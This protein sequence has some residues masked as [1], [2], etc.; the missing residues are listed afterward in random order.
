MKKITFL[1]A[2]IAS[3]ISFAQTTC[4]GAPALSTTGVNTVTAFGTEVSATCSGNGDGTGT[5]W[6]TYTATGDGVLNL[7][8]D[9]ASN[10]NADTRV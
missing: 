8:S 4:A 1:L 9:I 2:L 5:A 6:Y 3:S 7:S 10:N